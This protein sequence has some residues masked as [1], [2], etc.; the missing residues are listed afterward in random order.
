MYPPLIRVVTPTIA[1]SNTKVLNDIKAFANTNLLPCRQV[2]NTRL[3]ANFDRALMNL[4][5]R[6]RTRTKSAWRGKL[7]PTNIFS[8]EK[9]KVKNPALPQEN[10]CLPLSL[11]LSLSLSHFSLPPPSLSLSLSLSF[12]LSLSLSNFS[13]YPSLPLFLHL[14]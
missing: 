9:V 3:R 5:W 4:C 2:N 1:L 13:L 7:G 10:K 14:S 11:I 6:K 12:I 8:L